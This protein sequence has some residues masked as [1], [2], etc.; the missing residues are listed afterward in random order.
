MWL[1]LLFGMMSLAALSTL[2]IEGL[3]AHPT[4]TMTANR[5]RK[6][7]AAAITLADYTKSKAYT[8]E[9]LM[10]YTAG[11]YFQTDKNQ[12]R[13]WTLLG[14]VIRSAMQMGYHRDSK[15]FSNISVFEGEM[16]RRVWHIIYQI[17]IFSSF[18]VGLPH[19]IRPAQT[20]TEPPRNLHDQDFSVSSIELPPSRPETD[21]T[22]ILY[23]I[24]KCRMIVT[25]ATATE[26][27]H[28][29]IQPPYQD[30]LDLD[31]R[32]QNIHVSVP[33][34]MQ[35][36]SMDESITD[37]PL[38]IMNR[39]N[40]ELLYLKTR[41]VLH[42]RYLAMA[43]TDSRFAY[44]REACIDAA[45]KILHCHSIIYN[46]TQPGGQLGEVRW[47]MWTLN[48]HDFL[49]AAM[50][51]CL[52]LKTNNQSPR[53]FSGNVLEQGAVTHEDMV[54]ALQVSYK[55]WHTAGSSTTSEACQA[56]GVML[57]KIQDTVAADSSASNPPTRIA[58][59]GMFGR[60]VTEQEYYRLLIG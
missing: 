19:M 23:A 3:A 59:N 47:Y 56:I 58:Q 51:I 36:R 40:L 4:I 57:E 24:V 17:E 13:V 10:L 53:D 33:P 15:H 9:S 7:A 34:S 44:S 45:M 39:C 1:G 42:R 43:H 28:S 32:L 60:V 54:K 29:I 11:E 30:I 14:L 2:R 26:I 22:A 48:A 25:F 46:A 50:I 55:I 49:L 18:H 5:Y 27:S 6:H 41:C 31:N 37:S 21:I 20:D 8:I 16:R 12:I 35:M 38:L 52:E